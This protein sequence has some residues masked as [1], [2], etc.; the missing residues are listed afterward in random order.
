MSSSSASAPPELT[1]C[2]SCVTSA[3]DLSFT[4]A[5]A[6]ARDP[7]TPRCGPLASRQGSHTSRLTAS[8]D[9]IDDRWQ[10]RHHDLVP[11]RGD[12]GVWSA[13]RAAERPTDN[14]VSR[15]G[16]HIHGTTFAAT[17]FA[18]VDPLQPLIYPAAMFS[19]ALRVGYPI[20]PL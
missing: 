7:I 14:P 12:E 1:R 18:A 19:P 16:R 9:Q 10:S 2:S 13:R 11:T 6:G 5:P 20:R 15:R 8:Q 3:S 4:G 17:T